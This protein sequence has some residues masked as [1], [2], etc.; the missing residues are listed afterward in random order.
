MQ[1]QTQPAEPVRKANGSIWDN[2][3]FLGIVSVLAAVLVWMVVS[4]FLDPQ[5]SFVIKDV[6]V[7]YG[8]QSTIYTSKGLDIVDQQAVDNVQVQAD[9]NGTLIGKLSSSDIMVYPVY[10]GVQGAGKTT[11]RLEARITN[12]DYTNVGIKLTVLSP[13][14]VD[15]VF[16]TVGEKTL[17]VTTDTS[18]ITIAD[19][20]TLNRITT[21][22]TEVTLTGPTSELDKISEVVAPVSHE[23]SLSDSVSATA[24]LELRDENGDIVTPEYTT[25]DSNTADINLTV[26]Q[27]RELPLSIVFINAPSGFDTSYLK[28]SLSIPT[29]N[30]A[31]PN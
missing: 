2:R 27:V 25:L 23:G 10:N 8:Y 14:T 18:G 12:T 20:F 1:K 11:L 13:Q 9:G 26:Y 19:G 3:F 4:T 28:Y 15:V 22:P 6:S 24:S 21:T 29:L 16:D 30:V 5:G 31:G 17:P 7:N